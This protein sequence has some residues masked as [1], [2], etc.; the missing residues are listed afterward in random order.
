MD[1]IQSLDS[2][3]L[4][5]AKETRISIFWFR[6]NTTLRNPH[7]QQ[8]S[9]PRSQSW[10]RVVG[11]LSNL[12]ICLMEILLLSLSCEIPIT[13]LWSEIKTTAPH[14]LRRS[15]PYSL[16]CVRKKAKSQK[17]QEAPS[18]WSLGFSEKI[19]VAKTPHEMAYFFTQ[20]PLFCAQRMQ[21][22]DFLACLVC[23]TKTW[24]TR[25]ISL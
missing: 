19:V 13:I 6:K 20:L 2:N 11:I 14:A 7:I 8:T 5:R 18:W 24:S 9:Q 21:K 22:P 10:N 12:F 4:L 3:A 1:E 16:R 23:C 17:E 15:S 25:S